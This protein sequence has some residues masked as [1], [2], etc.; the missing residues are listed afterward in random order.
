M[1]REWEA[2]ETFGSPAPG[3]N[4]HQYLFSLDPFLVTESPVLAVQMATEKIVY[5]LPFPRQ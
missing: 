2:G 5:I 1:R 3:K 4:G